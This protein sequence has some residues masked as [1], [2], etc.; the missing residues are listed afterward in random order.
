MSFS[1]VKPFNLH[2]WIDENR[3]LL[4]PP[5]CNKQIFAQ[6]DFIVMV[7]G[8]PNNRSDYHYNETPELFYQQ[9]G[10]MNLKIIDE[11]NGIKTFKD[12]PIKAGEIFLLPPKMLH[13]PQR[14]ANSVGLVVEQK[15]PIEQKDALYWFCENCQHELYH[16]KFSLA[17]IEVDLPIVFNDFFETPAHCTCSECGTVATKN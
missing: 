9:E 11:Q 3:D 15:R 7:V 10:E 16:Q 1:Y 2:A 13:S 17:N 8:G 14:F 6:D 5:V 12:I 4:K